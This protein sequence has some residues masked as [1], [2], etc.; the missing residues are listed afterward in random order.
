MLDVNGKMMTISLAVFMF[1][2]P[3]IQGS[4]NFSPPVMSAGLSSIKTE[5]SAEKT[6]SGNEQQSEIE[7]AAIEEIEEVEEEVEKRYEA[8]QEELDLLAR[9]VYSEARGEPTQGQ[10][11]VAAVII[12]RL[13]DD[14]FPNTVSGVIFQPRA[15]T[16]VADGQF[17]YTPN[18]QAYKAVEMALEG[19]DPS[20]GA[21]YYYNP[22]T[23]TS[24][25]IFG[26][27]VIKRIGQ[28]LFAG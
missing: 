18:E 2:A 19:E 1:L 4:S 11:A 5:V 15:F 24:R 14:Q 17:W 6:E 16:A 25:W 8:D 3:L 27:P 12:N 23:A 9:A 7:A 28:H 20:D 10:V 22:A 26:R 13:E 21:L